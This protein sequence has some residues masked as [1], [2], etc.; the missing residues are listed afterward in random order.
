MVQLATLEVLFGLLYAVLQSLD[1]LE[2]HQVF[3]VGF[4][5][6]FLVLVY[7]LFE[8]L[9]HLA[10]RGSRWQFEGKFLLQIRPAVVHL[11]YL[12][13]GRL[14]RSNL[15][16]LGLKQLLLLATILFALLFIGLFLLLA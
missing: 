3:F 4:D 10:V 5:S 12:H 2:I 16:L 9:E 8:L 13:N 1:L 14:Q 6:V 7:F 15:F 11:L